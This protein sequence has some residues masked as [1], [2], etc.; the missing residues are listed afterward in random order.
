MF[1]C[2][3]E[4][5]CKVIMHMQIRQTQAYFSGCEDFLPTVLSGNSSG[6]G[7]SVRAAPVYLTKAAM[8][9]R[10]TEWR[11]NSLDAQGTPEA[12]RLSH[13]SKYGTAAE[14]VR[15]DPSARGRRRNREMASRSD[16]GVEPGTSPDALTG[17]P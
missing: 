2:L 7:L 9:R 15:G 6:E 16:G 1:R 17:E 13:W 5:Q 4:A 11:P 8:L 14:P 3:T 12:P 10:G